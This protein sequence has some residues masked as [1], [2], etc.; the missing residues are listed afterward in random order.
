MKGLHLPQENGVF[1]LHNFL[2]KTI[3]R[4]YYG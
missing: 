3:H 1:P 4:D 2:G